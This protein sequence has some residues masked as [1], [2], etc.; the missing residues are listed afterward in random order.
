MENAE[1]NL[2]CSLKNCGKEAKHR[3]VLLFWHHSKKRGSISYSAVPA[4][5]VLGLGLCDEHAKHATADQF[6]D[7]EGW[8]QIEAWFRKTGKALPTRHFTKLKLIPFDTC[9][10]CEGKMNG[11]QC[12]NEVCPSNSR[13]EDEP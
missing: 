7:A 12:T 2:K 13:K 4:K 3:P 10:V 8:K 6:I 1:E 11:S 5:A 9:M